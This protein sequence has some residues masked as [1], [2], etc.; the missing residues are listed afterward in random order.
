ME[1]IT[2]LR[3]WLSGRF[4]ERG[5]A[6]TEYVLLILGG[7]LFMIVAAFGLRG[8][9]TGAATAISSWVGSVSPPPIPTP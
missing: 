8:V 6:A 3:A 4:G 5:A 7:V 9:L 2:Y 1:V